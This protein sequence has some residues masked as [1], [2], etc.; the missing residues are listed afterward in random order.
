MP[1]LFAL[2]TGVKD[3]HP[4][5]L[6]RSLRGCVNDVNNVEAL[7]KKRFAE[8]DLHVVK[9]VNEQATRQNVIDNFIKHLI[10]NPG[11]QPGDLVLF[12]FSGHGSYARSNPAFSTWDSE[13]RDET[14]VLYDSRCKGGF[15]LADKELR[16]LLSRVP[17]ETHIT[18]IVDSCHSGSITRNVDA[19]DQALLGRAKHEP[20]RADDPGRELSAYLTV[21]GQGYEQLLD[22]NGKAKMPPVRCLTLSACDRTELAYESNYSPEGMFT[23]MLLEALQA[24]PV[25][26]NYARLYEHVY[27]LLKRKARKQTPQLAVSGGFDANTI[28]LDTKI[29]KGE[30]VYEVVKDADGNITVNC[31]ALHGMRNDAQSMQTVAVRL[32]D[33]DHPDTTVQTVK[34][35]AVGLD[36]SGLQPVAL[37]HMVYHA[38]IL[39]LP[40]AVCM[41]VTG[42]A[43]HLAAWQQLE[44]QK[45]QGDDPTIP[46]VNPLK[47]ETL[48]FVNSPSQHHDYVLQLESDRLVLTQAGTGKIIKEIADTSGKAFDYIM[49]C[50]NKICDWHQLL[51]MQNH[52]ITDAEYKKKFKIDFGV[53]L[54]NEATGEWELQP[55]DIVLYLDEQKQKIPVRIRLRTGSVDGWYCGVY[56]MDNR[57]GI[58]TL[59]NPAAEARVTSQQPQTIAEGGELRILSDADEI[60]DY[61]KL[62]VSKEPFNDFLIQNFGGFSDANDEFFGDAR[63]LMIPGKI[64]QDWYVQTLSIKLI[65]RSG[66]IDTTNSFAAGKLTIQPHTTVNARASLSPVATHAKS[67][68][69]AGILQQFV[70]ENGFEL[71]QLDAAKTVNLPSV[72]WVDGIEGQVTKENPLQITLQ[73]QP[74]DEESLLAMTVED[75]IIQVIGLGVPD[76][77]AGNYSIAITALPEDEQRQKNLARAAWFCFVKVVLRKDLSKLRLVTYMNGKVGYDPVPPKFV[78]P[79]MKVAVCIHGIIGNTKGIA[80]AMQF[81]QTEKQYDAILAFDYENLNKEIDEMAVTLKELLEEAGVS[82]DAPVD[83]ISHSMGGLVSRYMIE[84]IEGTAGWVNRLFMFGT[85]NAGSVLGDIPTIR[86]WTVTILTLACNYGGALLGAAAPVLSA[87]NKALAAT[88]VATNSLE[89]MA[90]NS[91]F[92]ALLNAQPRHPVTTQYHIIAGNVLT[93]VPAEDSDRFKKI[94]EKIKRQVGELLYKPPVKNDIAVGVDSIFSIPPGINA[95]Q[96]EIPGH[97]LNYF[98]LDEPIQYFKTL[99]N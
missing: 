49:Q 83:I 28:V 39:N 81:L 91:K 38:T 3:Y 60:T 46:H 66:R 54:Q 84:R 88:K 30:P 51:A 7:L 44:K 85:P 42:T 58:Q 56:Y 65:R 12:Y 79:G 15:D 13:G 10:N 63:P 40:P 34:I 59:S 95:T 53:E 23:A 89:Q 48:S 96:K 35:S 6:V 18:V 5:S 21:N 32:Y 98:E 64:D 14:L 33:K 77:Q 26:M 72:V 50:C 31:G 68:H 19:F 74:A 16:L 8:T 37:S 71:V 2:L 57:F 99:L 69:P 70:Q 94:M 80:T 25:N 11:I 75:G 41:Y 78:K 9:L 93:F 90:I 52:A 17:A 97:H 86:D 87:V 61:I 62:I 67:V 4:Q 73:E 43:P 76:K 24:G 45:R 1:R 82:K 22:A 47:N 36:K 55:N 20:A 29:E 92:L 27:T